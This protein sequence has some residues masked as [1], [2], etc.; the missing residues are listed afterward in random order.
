MSCTI[1]EDIYNNTGL[2]INKLTPWEI[3]VLTYESQYKVIIS[4][5]WDSITIL[6]TKGERQPRKFPDGCDVLLDDW[7]IIS[8]IEVTRTITEQSAER[9]IQRG[10]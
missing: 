1:P 6:I 5:T 4:G 3:G 8:E 10:L 9:A 7:V 2:K